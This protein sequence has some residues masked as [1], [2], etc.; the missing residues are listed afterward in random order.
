M[1][2]GARRCSKLPLF[3]LCY[4]YV[5]TVG[6]NMVRGCA[7]APLSLCDSADSRVAAAFAAR[8]A[9]AGV[10]VMPSLFLSVK[11]IIECKF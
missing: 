2:R 1:A 10:L 5:V 4:Q 11:I 8:C 9:A 6:F 3:F 7:I